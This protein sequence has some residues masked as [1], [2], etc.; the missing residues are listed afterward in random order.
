MLIRNA[1]VWAHGPADVRIAGGQ[2]T[3]RALGLR[4][5]PGEPVLDAAGGATCAGSPW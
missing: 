4:P 2:V 3:A 1:W 5:L